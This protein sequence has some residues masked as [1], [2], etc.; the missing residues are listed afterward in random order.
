MFRQNCQSR[1]LTVQTQC[2]F[3]HNTESSASVAISD[4][5]FQGT[6][7]TA[8]HIDGA[9]W[10]NP[11]QGFDVL[12]GTMVTPYSHAGDGSGSHCG[13]PTGAKNCW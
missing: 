13:K 10:F 1:A 2:F 3:C 5:R 11:L 12:S 4:P 6:Y 7:G 9:T 8:H